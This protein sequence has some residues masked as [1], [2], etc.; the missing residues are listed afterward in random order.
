M[1]FRFTNNANTPINIAVTN[2]RVIYFHKNQLAP[3]QSWSCQPKKVWYDIDVFWSTGSNDIDP[4]KQNATQITNLALVG[5]GAVVAV[6]AI[7]VTAGAA[8]PVIITGAGLAAAGG[9]IALTAVSAALNRAQVEALYGGD[10]YTIGV[11]GGVKQ[12][13]TGRNVYTLLPATINWT[14][15]TK[16]LSG[17]TVVSEKLGSAS[18]IT[19]GAMTVMNGS[20][21]AL[22]RGDLVQ[23]NITNGSKGKVRR[24]ESAGAMTALR[25]QLYAFRNGA[26]WRIEI[27]KSPVNIGSGW[28]TPGAMT[29]MGSFLYAF[30]GGKLWKVD[31]NGKSTNLGGGWTG[32][33]HMTALGNYL[34]VV[35]NDVLWR[36]DQNGRFLHLGERWAG[37][38]GM[39][40]L[41][42]SLYITQGG[43]LWKVKVVVSNPGPIR[44]NPRQK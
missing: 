19:A 33:L 37:T 25:N 42:D 35:Q 27:G 7:G 13:S 22:S 16:R 38:G 15:T 23:V 34:Y 28:V 29:A 1:T 4:A 12:L 32:T 14:N 2:G 11:T 31:S 30:Q 36:V 10:N 5:A 24:F 9:T 6:A 8:A 21:Y 3:G 41:G 40:A 18:W 43:N 20:V 26:L 39:A 44:L 17:M